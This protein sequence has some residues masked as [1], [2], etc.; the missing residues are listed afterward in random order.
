VHREGGFTGVAGG[1]KG[2]KEGGDQW[3][4]GEVCAVTRVPRLGWI[5]LPP[6]GAAMGNRLSVLHE[7]ELLSGG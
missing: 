6:F 7:K 1:K 4:S 5:P 2:L 3:L